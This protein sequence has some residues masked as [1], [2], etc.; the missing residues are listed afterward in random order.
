MLLLAENVWVKLLMFLKF[1]SV[2]SKMKVCGIR[3]YCE[4]VLHLQSNP[5]NIISIVNNLLNWAKLLYYDNGL[6]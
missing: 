2:F 1:F 3:I 6:E 5:S 4:L